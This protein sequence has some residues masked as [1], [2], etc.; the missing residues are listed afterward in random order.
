M[1]YTC[2][3][4]DF[5]TGDLT[6]I[7]SGTYA[8]ITVTGACAVA[9]DAVITVLGDI[10]VAPGAVLDAQSSP[11]TITVGHDVRQLGARFSAWAACLIHRDTRRDIRASSTQPEAPTSPSTGASSPGRGHRSA[12]RNHGQGERHADRIRRYSHRRRAGDRYSLGDQDQHD[13]RQPHC[14]RHD[15]LWIG[16]LVNK[17]RWQRDPVQHPH[18]RRAPREQRPDAR[19]S[20]SLA[21]RSGG[22]SSATDSP[23]PCREVS[24]LA[25]ST[26]SAAGRSVSAQTCRTND[27]RPTG[28]WESLTDLVRDPARPP[29]A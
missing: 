16:V 11:S 2:T 20:S 19:P 12:E 8:S 14:G 6:S 25:R 15:T 27:R 4:G 28:Q 7:P 23:Q 1:A 29:P 22:T 3:G 10:N 5:A 13:R 9:P 24:S 26:S 17:V 21:T 18:H